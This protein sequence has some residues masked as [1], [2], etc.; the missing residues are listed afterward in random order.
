LEKPF[1]PRTADQSRDTN[2]KPARGR[3]KALY[4]NGTRFVT[5]HGFSRADKR[6]KISRASAPANAIKQRAGHGCPKNFNGNKITQ[7]EALRPR[8]GR[9][10]RNRFNTGVEE[11]RL[12]ARLNIALTKI[13]TRYA[14]P[15]KP[16][17]SILPFNSLL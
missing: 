5:R 9:P 17:F 7:R 16:Q 10:R 3:P 8:S 11:M 15:W 2:I 6:N 13:L 4:K 1:Y 12:A 14:D